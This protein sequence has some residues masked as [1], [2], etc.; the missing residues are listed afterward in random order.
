LIIVQALT[1]IPYVRAV[2]VLV[3]VLFGL[4]AILL[5]LKSEFEAHRTG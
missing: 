4:G 2:V 1:F 5:V 3:G